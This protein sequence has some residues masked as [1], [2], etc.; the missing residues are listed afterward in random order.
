MFKT[1]YDVFINAVSQNKTE[2]FSICDTLFITNGSKTSRIV[3][4]S[5]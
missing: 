5:I 4:K 2:E 1:K 3:R